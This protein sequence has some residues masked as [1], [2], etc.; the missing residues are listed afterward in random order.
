MTT[1]LLLLFG[2]S[3]ALSLVLTPLFR[4]LALRCGLVD[5]PDGRRK[6]H[7]RVTPVAGGIVILVSA[8][9]ALL[10]L[11]LTTQAFPEDH[12]GSVDTTI[13]LVLASV[14]ICLVGVM[15]DFAM[16]RG[17]H[18][19][20][21]QA[22]AIAIVMAF[23]LRIETVAL[24]HWHIELGLLAI[25]FTAFFLLG[26]VNSLNLL[27]GM[28]GLLTM[29]GVIILAAMTVMA[30]LGGHW[31]PAVTA[32]VLVGSLLG[33]LRYNFPPATIFLGDSG[34][35]LIGLAIGVLAIQSSLKGPATMALAA[36]LATLTIP[37]LDTTA[38]I[39]RRKLT[40][41]SIYSTDRGHL[42]HCL[43]NRGLSTRS[44]LLWVSFFCLFTV[45][46]ALVSLALKNE[47]VALLS[48]AMVVCILV[49]IR[50]F[51][52]GEFLLA[53]NRLLS[54]AASFMRLRGPRKEPRASEVRLQGSVPWQDIWQQLVVCA[55]E[56]NLK[57]V[58]LD[59][60]APLIH[61]GYHARWDSQ[62]EE[63]ENPRLWFAEM[64]LM[65]QEQAIGRLEVAGHRDYEAVSTKISVLAEL[66]ESIE[67][68]VLE[69][70]ESSRPRHPLTTP[71]SRS[72][73]LDHARIGL[74]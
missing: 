56:L 41:R 48:G 27:D 74:Q 24:F 10:S 42:H 13:G 31:L 25:P 52:Y 49:G 57:N 9:I 64:P 44:V 54:M 5:R 59:V 66:V 7:A 2:V 69:A 40:G 63:S 71:I 30:A 22:L 6:T 55:G 34:S 61:E 37:I 3:L 28:D 67:A 17:R 38:A 39:I 1:T 18:K 46:G 23:G 45:S 8:G 43:L 51:G 20:L 19:L 58:C 26:A 68:R 12:A 14:L 32:V 47:S 65:V 36:P 21:G 4:A 15:D 73:N 70:V 53:R 16:L 72:V 60:N 29:I 35:M 33:F 11:A 62:H 50:I